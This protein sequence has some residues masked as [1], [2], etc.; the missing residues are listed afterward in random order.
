[1]GVSLSIQTTPGRL[2]IETR[3]ARLELK[4]RPVKLNMKVE[5]PKVEIDQSECFA[6]ANLKSP[7]E[8]VRE[9][10]QRGYQQAMEFIAKE[11]ANGDAMAAI[12]RGGNVLSQIAL[13]D[14][15][16]EHEF[17]MV[18]MPNARP[19]ITVKG[20]VSFDPDP[21]NDKGVTNGI[22]G[23]YIAGSINIQYTPA[24]IKIYASVNNSGPSAG[25]KIDTYR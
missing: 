5:L 8:F 25:L 4:S 14:S 13:E 23:Q 12:E 7:G 11:V 3:N 6:S 17:G 21:I 9:V 10:A 1:M 22:E 15:Y 24:Q 16:T 19:K 18:V 2:E 20:S